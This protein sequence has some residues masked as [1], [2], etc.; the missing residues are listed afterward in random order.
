MIEAK[1]HQLLLKLQNLADNEAATSYERESAR[2]KITELQEKYGVSFP[3]K[4]RSKSK[5]LTLVDMFEILGNNT[6]NIYL[7]TS[8][9]GI[10][11][12]KVSQYIKATQ[13]I[14]GIF[15]RLKGGI[16]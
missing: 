9:L 10:D 13:D 7:I 6:E 1:V 15:Q 8:I 11:K 12:T 5:K 16:K 14:V 2:R 3:V 4:I